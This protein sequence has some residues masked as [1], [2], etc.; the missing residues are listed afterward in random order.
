MIAPRDPGH[1]DMVPPFLRQGKTV[2]EFE[3]EFFI[4]TM[5]HGQPAP[6]TDYGILKIHDFPATNRGT[7]AT[8]NEFKG[9]LKKYKPEPTER[10]FANFHLLLYIADLLDVDTALTIATSVAEEKP[11]ETFLIELLESM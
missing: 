6:T 7:P 11:L 2:K 4:V 3:P 5:A 10:R 8:K 9:Y 1:S